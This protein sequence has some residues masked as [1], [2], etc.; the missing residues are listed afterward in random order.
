MPWGFIAAGLFFVVMSARDAGDSRVT[1]RAARVRA[2]PAA[3]CSI[4]V[5]SWGGVS[6]WP[7][8]MALSV[9]DFRVSVEKDEPGPNEPTA[10]SL[11]M[12]TR[13][14]SRYRVEAPEHE[15]EAAALGGR[16]WL[17]KGMAGE[18]SIVF[19]RFGGAAG[20]GLV[21][22]GCLVGGLVGLWR[23]LKRRARGNRTT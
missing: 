18:Y 15:V 16:Q 11:E 14:G 6:I 22:V 1:C 17:S 13:D 23:D 2:K 9:E 7:A 4:Q 8:Q 5:R 20:A 10:Y 19:D 12:V 3:Y 21:G